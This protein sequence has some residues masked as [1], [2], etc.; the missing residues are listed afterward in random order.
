MA[1]LALPGGLSS[2]RERNPSWLKWAIAIT[3]SLGAI[4]EVIDTS[5]VN[6]ALTDMQSTL[7]ATLSEVGWV[8]TSY[9]IAN[10]II[11]PLTAWLGD[12]FGNKRYFIFSLI[13]FT[14]ASML[15]GFA[16]SLPMLIFARILQGLGGGGLLAKAQ[17]I[18][19]RT[20]PREEQGMAQALFGVGVIA[21]PVIGPTLGGYIVTNLDWRWIFFI[22]LPFGILAVVMAM[23]FLPIDPIRRVISSKVD[24]LGIGLLVV[25]IGA[26]QTMLEQGQADDW[27]QSNFICW[28]AVITVFGLSLFIWREL[29]V[30]YPSVDLHVLRFRSITAGSL[31]SAVLGMGLYGAIF[32]VPIFTQQILG[33]TAYQTGML[34]FPG[35]IAAA[36]M[37]PL[38]G[39][40][41]SI[42][43]NRLL[44]AFGACVI[45]ASM[46]ALATM[47]IN[48]SYESLFW[49]MVFRS[50]GTVFMFLPLS[51]ASLGP[52]PPK[53]ISAG[54]GF[55][56][57]TRQMGGSIGIAI[58][59]TMLAT[60]EGFHRAVLSESVSIY[61]EATRQRLTM[62][63]QGF[64]SKGAST[65]V[66]KQQALA[67]INGTLN[68]QAAIMSFGDTF[69]FVAVAF[70]CMLP[71]LFLLGRGRGAVGAGAH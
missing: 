41:V 57:L 26:L 33:F 67:A 24:W 71:L 40:L 22:N 35:A 34:L 32:A 52:L 15:C 56:N 45:V 6:V 29:T 42:F 49:P 11:I 3:A 25:W 69:N 53:Y 19:F 51:L 2:I 66:A 68:M 38:V 47:N 50:V 70:L 39:R 13:A 27:F 16:T 1:S 21:G 7:G 20:F 10:V 9:A 62:L 8:I 30:E 59:T 5:I 4:L 44:I 17:A 48:S 31:F 60:R 28:L 37:M 23:I 43:D 14:L 63:T 64:I 55:Y 61:S 54:S 36:I 58:L 46:M 12:Y 65:P 18:L